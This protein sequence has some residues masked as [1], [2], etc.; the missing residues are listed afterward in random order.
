MRNIILLPK[1]KTWINKDGVLCFKYNNHDT[2][3]KLEEPRVLDYI[4]AICDLAEGQPTPILIDLRDAKGTISLKAAKLF[5]SNPLFNEVKLAEAFVLNSIGMKLSI[6]TYKRLYD[7]K[8]PHKIFNSQHEA[9]TYCLESKKP[10][11]GIY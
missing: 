9:N 7:P 8:T 1:A 10:A 6:L 3:Y 4:K 5:A 11:D 2:S